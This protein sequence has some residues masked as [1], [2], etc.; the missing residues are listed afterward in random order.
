M[1]NPLVSV[2]IPC[3]RQPGHLRECLAGLT[4]DR[5][6]GDFEIIV[7]D[8]GSDDAVASVAAGF[9]E[10][11]IVSSG[12]RLWAGAARNLGSRAARG[13]VLL[14]L[15]ADCVPEPGWVH[16]G[17][18]VLEAGVR[19]AG[20]PVLDLLPAHPI[21]ASDNLLQFAEF[22]STR[23]GGAATKFPAC[24]LGLR[25]TDFETLGGFPEEL[26]GGEDTVLTRAAL[27][28]WPDGLRF[29]PAMRVRHLGRTKFDAFLVHQTWFG[30]YRGILGTDLTP[31]QRRLAAHAA[32]MPAVVLKRLSY[33]LRRT[34]QWHPLGL[35]RALALSPL[36][37]AG[38]WAYAGGLRRGLRRS[39]EPREPW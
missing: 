36:L 4:P 14:F 25:S 35:P 31:G 19:M 33:V 30:Y 1:S 13:A 32:V 37:L 28:R 11:R 34:I 24:N 18:A 21:A 3:Y 20:G 39:R 7:V 22:P 2:I 38:L 6:G 12:A 29:V 9:P 26:A 23:P 27:I 5:Q 8:S 17:G 15:D 16:A 10:V